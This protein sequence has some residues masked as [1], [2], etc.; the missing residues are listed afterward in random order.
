MKDTAKNNKPGK[1]K[2]KL[3]NNE[4]TSSLSNI[5][6]TLINAR[7]I[8]AH[9][10]AIADLIATLDLNFLAITETWLHAAAS[11]TLSIAI[12]EGYTIFRKDRTE[13]FLLILIPRLNISSES[14]EKGL[15]KETINEETLQSI[16]AFHCHSNTKAH[17][18]RQKEQSLAKRKLYIATAICLAF[19][20]GEL[21]G[22]YIAGSLAIITDAAHLLVDLMSFLIS[23][24]SLWLSS[25]PATQRLTFGWH[26]A[27]ILGALFSMITIWIVTGVLVYL[28][29]E[30]I[31]RPTYNIEGTIMLITSICALVA[32]IILGFTLHQGTHGHSHRPQSNQH[33]LE[34]EH[35]PQAN[36]SVRAAF[37]HAIGDLFQGISVL[38]SALIIF[39]KPE[40]KIAD[41]IC[42]FIFSIFVLATT[43][44][45]LRDILLLLMEGTPW[46]INH[47]A[48]KEKILAVTGVKSVHSLH[49]WALTMNQVILSAHVSAADTVDP[50]QT[51]REITEVVFDSFTFH[52]VTI[53]VEQEADQKHGCTFCQDPKD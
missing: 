24:C 29:C 27:E 22:G 32:N 34:S 23:L 35:K 26:R 17:D 36:A 44:T 46:G 7:S 37:I 30:R 12:L 28:A 5:K 11:P 49:L 38:I 19:L 9:A 42:T 47:N 18:A 20:I 25:K 50:Q 43:V 15:D 48:V 31:R 40:Y 45:I 52:S 39:L 13:L 10:L 4:Q 6:G 2:S 51:L 21:V 14:Q 1:P 16:G 3:L 41:P 8:L 53:Q 33:I